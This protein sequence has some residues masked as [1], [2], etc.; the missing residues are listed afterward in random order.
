MEWRMKMKKQRRSVLLL[1]AVRGLVSTHPLLHSK[2]R[3]ARPSLVVAVAPDGFD[4]TGRQVG[5]LRSEHDRK[6]F[7][8][9]MDE[10]GYAYAYRGRLSDRARAWRSPLLTRVWRRCALDGRCRPPWY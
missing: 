6:V 7:D 1:S 8:V 3:A 10:G 9:W 4:G 5:D 2:P